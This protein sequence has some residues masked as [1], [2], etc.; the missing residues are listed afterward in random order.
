MQQPSTS[1][2]TSGFL[3]RLIVGIAGLAVFFLLFFA[4][5]TN[6]TNQDGTGIAAE[7]PAGRAP[8]E[9]LPPLGP[10]PDF[11]RQKAALA[12]ATP[13]VRMLLLDSMVSNLEA[14]QRFAYAA[15]Y[16]GMLTE[17]DSSLNARLRAGRLSQMATQ[18]FVV[19]QDSNLFRRYSDQAIAQLRKVVEVDPENETGLLYLGLALTQSGQPQNSMQGIL[20][21]RKVLE[22]NP[23]NVEA[24]Y[25]L[26]LFSIQTGQYEK[27]EGRFSQVL[28]ADP[29]FQPARLQ[30]A[31]T[32]IQLGRTDE[33]RPLLSEVLQQAEDPELKRQARAL[34]DQLPAS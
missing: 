22:I 34:L 28:E 26:G 18:S 29:T 21:I 27:A 30:L 15:D 1:S 33:A 17:L 25:Q 3:L 19:Q 32:L 23:D 12:T 6:L 20:T 4:D 16:A 24:G 8:S 5:K 14:R 11:D 31:F 9:G 2:R 13:E 10:D 7:P